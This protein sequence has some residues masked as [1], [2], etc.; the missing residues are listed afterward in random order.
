M[1]VVVPGPEPGREQK[2]AA[3]SPV[4][5]LPRGE[6]ADSFTSFLFF[7]SW[8]YIYDLKGK[9]ASRQSVVGLSAPDLPPAR[10]FQEAIK[11][12][13]I[14]ASSPLLLALSSLKTPLFFFF[15]MVVISF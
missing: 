15:S 9:D 1:G 11:S 14:S 13:H 8:F 3:P 4:Y 12:D 7:K 5:D 2:A 10:Q 6:P